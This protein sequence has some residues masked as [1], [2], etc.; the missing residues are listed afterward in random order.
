MNATREKRRGETLFH[1]VLWAVLG[2]IALNLAVIGQE[3]L[4]SPELG[5]PQGVI[6]RTVLGAI[7]GIII[8]A[9]AAISSRIGRPAETASDVNDEPELQVPQETPDPDVCEEDLRIEIAQRERSEQALA[10]SRRIQSAILDNIPDMAWLKDK[11]GKFLAVND[12]FEKACGIPRAELIGKTDFDYWPRDVA[13][14]YRL[15]DEQVMKTGTHKSIEETLVHAE[16]K[17][18]WIETIKSPIYD[19][20]GNVIGTTGISRD[21]TQRKILE[22]KLRER[23]AKTIK[24]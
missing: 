7:A 5:G 15:D 22:Q 10:E 2:G 3:Y 11:E 24:L 9:L 13:E 21:I 1:V 23:L 12:A 4:S 8:G 19:E 6:G 14:K 16:D 20:E 18:I 17:K